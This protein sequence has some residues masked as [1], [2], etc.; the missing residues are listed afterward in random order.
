MKQ[1][2]I[3]YR[4]LRILQRAMEAEEFDVECLSAEALGISAAMWARILKMLAEEGYIRGVKVIESDA[5][6]IPLIRMTRPEITLKGLE[7]LEENAMMA[8]AA[9]LAKGISELIP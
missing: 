7:Y 8:K 4:V 6:P 5:S 3:I 9:R 2:K 1:F